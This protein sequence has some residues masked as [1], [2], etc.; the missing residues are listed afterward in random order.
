MAEF[1][2]FQLGQSTK[3]KFAS[4][5]TFL[6]E[7]QRPEDAIQPLKEESKGFFTQLKEAFTGE[8]LIDPKTENLPEIG[9]VESDSKLKVLGSMLSSV[10]PQEQANI[11]ESNIEGLTQRQDDKGNIVVKFPNGNEAFV[12]KAGFSMT[13]FRNLVTEGVQFSPRLN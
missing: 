8:N 1:D 10:D 12:N 6:S 9:E 4:A 5:E 3:P 11:L 13:D 2:A 7:K